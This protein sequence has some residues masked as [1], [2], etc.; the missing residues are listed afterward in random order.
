MFKRFFLNFMLL[1]FILI[2]VFGQQ[3]SEYEVA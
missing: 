2:T 3:L 1:L